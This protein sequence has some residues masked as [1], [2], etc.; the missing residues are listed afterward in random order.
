MSQLTFART[1]RNHQHFLFLVGYDDVATWLGQQVERYYGAHG[2]GFAVAFRS[3]PELN[4][5]RLL[6]ASLATS[7]DREE[8]YPGSIW[9]CRF[10]ECNAI[11][12]ANGRCP[13]CPAC[14]YAGL[15]HEGGRSLEHLQRDRSVELADLAKP[16][17]RALLMALPNFA[18]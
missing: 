17:R 14:D 9:V 4:K 8:L 3:A 13:S 10:M 11:V 5:S 12:Y 18:V 6:L 1:R 7:F 2:S 16:A 15:H